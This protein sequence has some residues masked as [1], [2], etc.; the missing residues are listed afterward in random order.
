VALSKPESGSS[1]TAETSDEG[2][3]QD[4]GDLLFPLDSEIKLGIFVNKI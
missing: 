1:F 2:K 4:C 3:Y